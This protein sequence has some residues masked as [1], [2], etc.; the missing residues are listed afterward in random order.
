M[1]FRLLLH[2]ILVQ[3]IQ[4]QKVPRVHDQEV[5]RKI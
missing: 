3:P 1:D 4:N 5:G 2:H